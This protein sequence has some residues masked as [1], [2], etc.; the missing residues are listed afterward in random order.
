MFSLSWSEMAVARQRAVVLPERFRPVGA[1]GKHCVSADSAAAGWCLVSVRAVVGMQA[2]S[3]SASALVDRQWER[4]A[5]DSLMED[6]RSGC[7][8]SLIH[9]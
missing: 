3:K 4:Q 9:I 7:G 6:L 2:R 8:L 1:G 5:L